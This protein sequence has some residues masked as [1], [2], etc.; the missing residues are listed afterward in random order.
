MFRLTPFNQNVVRRNRGNYSLS[1]YVSDFFGDDF[2]PM[3]N[4]RYDTFKVDVKE[5]ENRFIIEADLPGFKKEEIELKYNEGLLTI[6]IEHDETKEEEETNYVHRERKQCSMKRT[7]NLG[8][9][10]FDKI[11]ASLKDGILEIIA[12]KAEIVET[13]KRIEIK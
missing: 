6:S 10:D 12:P 11:D 13:T 1:D 2:L 7:L 4:L 8:E 5:E 3:R 9:L